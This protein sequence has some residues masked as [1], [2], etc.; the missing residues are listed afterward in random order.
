MIYRVALRYPIIVEVEVEAEDEL[1]AYEAAE[2]SAD[3]RNGE[4]DGEPA[5]VEAE[6]GEEEGQ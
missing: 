1:E 6:K 5:R 3:W 2:E 4:E